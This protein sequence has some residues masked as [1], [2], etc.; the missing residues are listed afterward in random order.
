MNEYAIRLLN[1]AIADLSL[2]CEPSHNARTQFTVDD[3]KEKMV[4]L[5]AAVA[6]AKA[7]ASAGTFIPRYAELRP[8]TELYTSPQPTP[9]L[10]QAA[11]LALE[12]LQLTTVYLEKA[13]D[14]AIRR[15]ALPDTINSIKDDLSYHTRIIQTLKTALIEG[16]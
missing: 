8:G 16:Q 11:H 12:Q 9:E 3:N 14:R 2:R 6:R 5:Q 10:V 4:Q 13:L 7:N 1:E 15:E